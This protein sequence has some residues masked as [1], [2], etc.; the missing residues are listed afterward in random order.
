VLDVGFPATWWA[1]NYIFDT[2]RDQYT[3]RLN[4]VELDFG[5]VGVMTSLGEIKTTLEK[6]L[7]NPALF[8]LVN[9]R[10]TLKTG[11][12]LAVIPEA[13]DKSP[14]SVEKVIS[15]LQSMGYS[16]NALVIIA[17]SKK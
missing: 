16:V 6:A 2:Q 14:A 7:G 1:E 9:T 5:K 15:C 11:V 17:R 3:S 10:I 4:G 12:D 8:S 13:E